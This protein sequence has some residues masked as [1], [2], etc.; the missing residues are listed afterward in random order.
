MGYSGVLIP[1]LADDPNI[2]EFTKHQASWIGKN[3]VWCIISVLHP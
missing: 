1:Q 2:E 3:S